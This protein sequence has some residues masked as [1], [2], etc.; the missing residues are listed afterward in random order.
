M[1]LIISLPALGDCSLGQAQ[2][3]AGTGGGLGF[4]GA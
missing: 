3:L 4:E 2:D 1:L